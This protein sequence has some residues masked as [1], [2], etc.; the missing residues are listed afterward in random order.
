[1]RTAL[2]RFSPAP[3]GSSQVH[4]ELPMP[5][6]AFGL[7]TLGTLLFLLLVT[8]AFRSVGSRH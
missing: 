7:L 8:W 3:E 6:E 5:P 2:V 1:M 4:S